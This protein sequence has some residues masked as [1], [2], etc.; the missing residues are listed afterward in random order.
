MFDKQIKDVLERI[1]AQANKKEFKINTAEE[2]YY[3]SGLWLGYVFKNMKGETLKSGKRQEAMRLASQKDEKHFRDFLCGIFKTEYMKFNPSD[4]A[5]G[6]F[7]AIINYGFEEPE[8]SYDGTQALS[9]GL[10]LEF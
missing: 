6:V 1:E 10:V 9:Q 2:W 5:D 4:K 8:I 7:S 3:V